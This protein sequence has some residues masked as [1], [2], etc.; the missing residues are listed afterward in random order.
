MKR[1]A[2]ILQW[3][4][5]LPY[6]A[7]FAA[8]ILVLVSLAI[9]F[10]LAGVLWGSTGFATYALVRRVVGFTLPVI[11]V[12]VE[13]GL[14]RFIALGGSRRSLAAEY[15]V[16]ALIL[17]AA[18]LTLVGLI[19]YFWKGTVAALLFGSRE[20]T[21]WLSPLMWLLSGYSL[22]I[23]IFAYWRG[24]MRIG[25]AALLYV[26]AFAIAP[27]C[28]VLLSQSGALSALSRLGGAAALVALAFFPAHAVGMPSAR[29]PYAAIVELLQYGAPRVIGS[30]ALLVLFAMPALSAA[31]ADLLALSGLLAFAVTVVGSLGSMVGP[32][33]TILLPTAARYAGK[34]RLDLLRPQYLSCVWLVSVVGCLATIGV[35]A[36]AD[37]ILRFFVPRE[38]LGYVTAFQLSA[39]GILPY[40]YFCL[41]RHVIDAHSTL[42]HNAVSA[43]L[44]LA[45]FVLVEACVGMATQSSTG[46]SEGIGL[47]AALCV[48]AWRSH[49][50]AWRVLRPQTVIASSGGR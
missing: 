23:V 34:G 44:A 43:V 37:I 4:R 46:I 1:L 25:R 12:G 41:A 5:L 16:A 2:I 33:G 35:V 3:K 6:S 48:L 26:L 19:V 42:P 7:T 31:H 20:Y 18:T 8:E 32:I 22:Y 39:L 14:P 49:I 15:L 11:T 13:V 50:L 45:S 30:F 9:C 27:V 24:T 29:K 10:R 28:A 17:C 36:G 47:A 38:L 40:M 21:D